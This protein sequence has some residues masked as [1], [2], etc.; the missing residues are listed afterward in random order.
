MSLTRLSNIL[1]LMALAIV[2]LMGWHAGFVGGTLTGV[3]LSQVGN[4]TSSAAAES[5]PLQ[6][7]E[8]PTQA[9]ETPAPASETPVASPTHDTEPTS[10]P[11]ETAVVEPDPTP[12]PAHLPVAYNDYDRRA[13]GPV[14]SEAIGYV[15]QL[16]AGGR[17]RCAPATH[18]LATE[19][20]G[21]EANAAVFAAS[22]DPR[23]ELDLYLGEK[24]RVRGV[25]FTAPQA[26]SPTRRIIAA[27]EI[28]EII[29]PPGVWRSP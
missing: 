9:S 27:T 11:D 20:G 24:V 17:E 23:L 13:P 14:V 19:P 22:D 12:Q 26:C 28:E 29:E 3:G 15:E 5:L 7:S 25:E 6:A 16:T 2:G 1:A 10:T 4:L 18:L 21:Q 8:T